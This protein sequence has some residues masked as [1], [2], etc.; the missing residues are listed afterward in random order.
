MAGENIK[1]VCQNRKA[2]HEYEIIQVIEAGMVL[3]GPEAKS[4]REGRANLSDSYAGFQ[5]GELW[6]YNFHISPYPHAKQGIKLDPIRPRKLLLHKREI[7][8]LIG[9]TQEKGLTL[10][11]LRIYF[12]RGRAKAELGLAKGKKLHDKRRSIKER[13]LKRELRREYKKYK[14]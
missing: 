13:E 9:K 10:I 4:L 8:K 2:R 11:P 6:L 7:R 1:I 5:R 12:K 14:I 3:L